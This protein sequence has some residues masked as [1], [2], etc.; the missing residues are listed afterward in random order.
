MKPIEES[1]R[2]LSAKW[3]KPLE[4]G[5]VPSYADANYR[6]WVEESL[7]YCAYELEAILA[8]QPADT[9]PV[10]H[11]KVT[12][13]MLPKDDV[14]RSMMHG[15]NCPASALGNDEECLCGLKWRVALATEQTMH[16]A[17]RKRAEQAER[18]LADAVAA[19]RE[20]CAKLESAIRDL[21]TLAIKDNLGEYI[22]ASQPWVSEKIAA[23]RIAIRATP[24]S[25]PTGTMNCPRCGK[26]TPHNHNHECCWEGKGHRDCD[27]RKCCVCG[28]N[29]PIIRNGRGYPSSAAALTEAKGQ[30]PK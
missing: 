20:R 15:M 26:N 29:A 22:P 8:A 27:G 1:L 4:H 12:P 11:D 13:G 9:P 17:W 18:E 5:D 2:E 28:G 23:V 30:E 6:R 16:N 3:R 14:E 25:E 24:A 21:L 10:H 19:E 7:S